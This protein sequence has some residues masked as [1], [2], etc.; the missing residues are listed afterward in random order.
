MLEGKPSLLLVVRLTEG[1]NIKAMNGL[2]EFN[3][4]H[5]LASVTAEVNYDKELQIFK[6]V[7][8]ENLKQKVNSF[9]FQK[10]LNAAVAEQLCFERRVDI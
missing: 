8:F 4:E 2:D 10:S 7:I 3:Q 5:H 1:V 9:F 6:E